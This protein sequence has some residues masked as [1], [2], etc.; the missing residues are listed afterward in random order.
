MKRPL[1]VCAAIVAALSVALPA[2]AD[3]GRSLKGQITAISQHRISIKSPNSIVTS[4]AVVRVSP[5]LDG[6][7]AGDAVQAV[8]HSR[9]GHLVLARIR[10]LP[11]P[12]PPA[13]K[14]DA[15]STTFGGAIT[16]LSD[17]SI[18]LRDGDRQITCSIV[19][20]SPSTDGY[21]VGQHAKVSCAGGTL[22]AIAPVTT[23][24]AGRYYVGTVSALDD[25]SITLQTE[26]GPATCTIG[27]GSPST[28]ALHLG[29]RIGMGCK[30]ST[31]QLVLIRK[32]DGGSTSPT[33]PTTHTK[34]GARGTLS[35]VTETSVSVTTDGGTVTCTRGSSSPSLGDAA[36]GDHVE[37]GC[38]DG[39]LTAFAKVS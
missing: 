25:K 16:A 15:E 13:T 39:V 19:S 37:M 21:K 9:R 31:M 4:C 2:A 8:C 23:A 1:F 12:A 30:A 27:P 34:T 17:D 7:A 36:V 28:A 11:R 10:H 33:E 18:T 3:N 5:S 6:Y 22:V 35:A 20:S 29:D 38:L 32:V 26:H 14:N 24:D